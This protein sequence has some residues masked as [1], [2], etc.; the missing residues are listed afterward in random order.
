[1]AKDRIELG[2]FVK[3]IASGPAALFG[4]GQKGRIEIGADADFVVFDP[5]TEWTLDENELHHS[6][7]WSPYHGLQV[8]GRVISTWLRGSCIYEDGEILA[9][10]GSGRF[11]SP[12]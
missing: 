7:D 6:V 10:A 12:S 1:M 8:Q 11:I 2:Q 5:N 3:L 4:F 9:D